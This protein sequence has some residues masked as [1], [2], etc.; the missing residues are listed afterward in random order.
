MSL[1]VSRKD[2][3][4]VAVMLSGALL[5]VLNLTLLSPALPTI[6]ADLGIERTTAQWLTSG[7]SLVEACVIPLSAY[8]M[9]RFPMRKLFIAGMCIFGA[10]RCF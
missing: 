10:L 5:A 1:G 7:Y 8:L 4:M 3:V 2:L 6:M 9:G